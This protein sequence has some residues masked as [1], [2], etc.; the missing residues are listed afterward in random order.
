MNAP[1]GHSVA[2]VQPAPEHR[3]TGTDRIEAALKELRDEMDRADRAG[4]DSSVTDSD[5]CT[6]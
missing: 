2:I 3:L 1:I 4:N 6:H 5:G